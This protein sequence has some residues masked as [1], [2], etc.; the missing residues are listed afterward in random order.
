MKLVAPKRQ[1]SKKTG[2]LPFAKA[3][4]VSPL[5]NVLT[6]EPVYEIAPNPVRN[7][8]GSFT[9][10]KN[11]FSFMKLLMA[12]HARENWGNFEWI[13][14][15]Q[16]ANSILNTEVVGYGSLNH[17]P[18]LSRIS[19]IS[20]C[21]ET[22]LGGMYSGHSFYHAPWHHYGSSF[23]VNT[24]RAMRAYYDPRSG[25]I[26][27]GAKDYPSVQYVA[28]HVH[29][30]V[31]IR[32]STIDLFKLIASSLPKYAVISHI[33]YN[34]VWGP[35]GER[36]EKYASQF[37]IVGN[38]DAF[39]QDLLARCGDHYMGI[40]ILGS[41]HLGW[42]F[43]GLAGAANLFSMIP[44]NALILSEWHPSLWTDEIRYIKKEENKILYDQPCICE[45]IP[46]SYDC[47]FKL[48]DDA[49]SLLDARYKK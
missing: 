17:L 37:R 43:I 45:P 14:I 18:C 4:R 20:H 40:Q 27:F 2:E 25:P 21:V 8:D 30:K 12:P 1:P 38:S 28:N 33:K 6:T 16:Y 11:F 3:K 47:W 48:V 41:V 32:Q 49:F 44:I 42:R 22:N 39:K 24:K 35:I 15:F 9:F 46:P 31:L 7:P 10:G 26:I 19:N 13:R 5:E 23:M 36:V 29:R 34:P